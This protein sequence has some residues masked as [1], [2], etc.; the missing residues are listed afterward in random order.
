MTKVVEITEFGPPSVLK[1]TQKDLQKLQPNEVLVENKSI[2]LNFIDTYHRTG[3][4]RFLFH[5]V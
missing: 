1:I 2:G 5:L 3:L 4:T